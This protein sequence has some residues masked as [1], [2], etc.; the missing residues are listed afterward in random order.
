MKGN[1]MENILVTGGAGYIGSHMTRLLLEHKYHPIVFDNMSTGHREFIPEGAHF[2]KGDLRNPAHIEKVFEK[3]KIGAIMHFAASIV[4]PESVTDPL[5][6]YENNIGGTLNL[7]RAMVKAKVR[8]FIFSSTATVYGERDDAHITEEA[9]LSAMNPYARTKYMI[10]QILQDASAA[11]DVRHMIFRYFNV[12]GSHPSAEIG[13]KMANPT[14]LIPNIMKVFLGKKKF[15]NVFGEDYDT[16]DG[17]CIR[18]YIYVMDLCRA[19]L[20][21]LESL[22]RGM[23][24]DIF[25]LGSG[26]GFSVKQVIAAA[27]KVVGRKIKIK[28]AARRPGD[29]PRSVASF[30]KAHKILGWNPEATLEQIINTAWDFEKASHSR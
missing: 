25:N 13:I 2:I 7:M 28:S 29:V 23:T 9:P 5:K 8:F 1:A 30:S 18:D 26:T 15:L 21:A 6:Y 12:A 14:H 17:T 11:H 16:P 24:S 22:K 20:L 10:E 19:H 4:V 27:Q 3:Y